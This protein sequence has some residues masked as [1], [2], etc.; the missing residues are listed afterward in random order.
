VATGLPAAAWDDETV[1]SSVAD[2]TGD[3]ADEV[4]V[5]AT[6]P[7]PTSTPAGRVVVLDVTGAEPAVLGVLGGELFLPELTVTTAGSTVTLSGPTVAG[8][9]PTCCPGHLGTVTYAWDGARF[10]VRTLDEV[11]ASR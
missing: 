8:T 4:L 9:D 3:G 10:V 11:P 7:S 5:E 6:C 1:R 2:V